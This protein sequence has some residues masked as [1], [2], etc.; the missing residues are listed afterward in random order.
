MDVAVITG[1]GSGIGLGTALRFRD[2]GYAVLGV[3]RDKGKL[4]DLERQFEDKDRIAT[5]SLDVTAA[6]APALVVDH[7]MRR[8]GQLNYLINNA[9]VGRPTPVDETDDERLDLF[10][11]LM[12]RAPFRLIRAALPFMK[13]GASIVNVTSTHGLVG[14]FRAGPYAAAKGGLHALTLHLAAQ[15]GPLGIRSNCVAPG[16]TPTPMTEGRYEDTTF[17]R[18]NKHMTPYPRYGTV[19]DVVNLI[20]FLCAPQSGFVNGQIIAVDGGWSSTKYLSD[21]ARDAEWIAKSKIVQ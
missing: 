14:G 3:G 10:L 19:D 11:N 6:G 7:A 9:G 5:L 8:W 17:Q 20:A 18:M 15:Y 16:V 4:D 12:L 13:A 1:A 21:F 2:L